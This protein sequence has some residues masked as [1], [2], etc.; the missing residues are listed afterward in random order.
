MQDLADFHFFSIRTF[1]STKNK[2][3]LESITDSVKIKSGFFIE[4]G[5]LAV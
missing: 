4:N 1:P 2:V 5:Y 3:R